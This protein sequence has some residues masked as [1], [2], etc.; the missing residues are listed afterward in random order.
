MNALITMHYEAETEVCTCS[1]LGGCGGIESPRIDC[2][3]HG[4]LPGQ[5][6]EVSFHTHPL[7]V[8]GRINR[9]R[10]VA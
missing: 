5:V 3:E 4:S 6:V 1:K 8:P 2:P 7:Q 9:G 10:H